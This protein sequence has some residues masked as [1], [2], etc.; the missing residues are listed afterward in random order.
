MNFIK[1]IFSNSK[2]KPDSDNQEEAKD[3]FLDEKFV[4]N[5]NK[6]SG[7]FLYCTHQEEVN[8]N[9]K[10]ILDE[11]SWEE[12]LC[13]DKDLEKLLFIANSNS[14]EKNKKNIPFFTTC[15]NLIASDGNIM[16]TS[17]QLGEKKIVDLPIN[18][19]VFAKTS[20]LINDKGDALISINNNNKEIP[21]NI[22]AVKC[23]DPNKKD[24]DFMNYGNNNSKNLYLLLLEDL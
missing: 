22:G 5:F 18:F 9:L 23:Y 13:F 12:A 11:N 7:K 19:I 8:Q 1:R 4:E 10:N 21:T 16:F 14:T 15:E 17:N 6:K 2:N 3:L 20:Q 24:D